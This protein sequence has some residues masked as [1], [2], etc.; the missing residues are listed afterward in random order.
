MNAISPIR[1]EEIFL[2]TPPTHQ[3]CTR[4]PLH[5][6]SATT[7]TDG[8]HVA[9]ILVVPSSQG[10]SNGC[11]FQVLLQQHFL[12]GSPPRDIS[13]FRCSIPTKP[14]RTCQDVRPADDPDPYMTF[15]LKKMLPTKTPAWDCFWNKQV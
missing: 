9:L 13:G 12:A 6:P 3:V 11:V 7:I 15:L 10:R 14:R 5:T 8:E 2:C 1:G 4:Q